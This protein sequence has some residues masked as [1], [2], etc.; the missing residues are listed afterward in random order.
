VEAVLKDFNP[1]HAR[2]RPAAYDTDPTYTRCFLSRR[3]PSQAYGKMLCWMLSSD[4]EDNK[5]AGDAVAAAAAAPVCG[6]DRSC[7][8]SQVSVASPSTA[9]ASLHAA[10]PPTLKLSHSGGVFHTAIGL[11][12]PSVQGCPGPCWPEQRIVGPFFLL[13]FNPYMPCQCAHSHLS[14]DA[15]DVLLLRRWRRCIGHV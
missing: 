11:P 3:S 1:R 7:W 13:S 9:Q 4:R 6:L 10:Y 5:E 2:K 15:C 14:I 12:V 8:P